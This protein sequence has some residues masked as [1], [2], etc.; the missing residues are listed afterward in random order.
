MKNYLLLLL[1]LACFSPLSAQT[2]PKILWGVYGGLTRSF[3]QFPKVNYQKTNALYAAY[4]D[5]LQEMKGTNFFGIQ[6]GIMI[7]FPLVE[8]WQ[9]RLL[10]CID[11]SQADF[12]HIYTSRSIENW[13]YEQTNLCLPIQAVW[14]MT[15]KEHSFYAFLGLNPKINFQTDRSLQKITLKKA[16]VSL[17]FGV[18]YGKIKI[19]KA[20]PFA[21]ELRFSLG[22]RDRLIDENSL[23]YVTIGAFK[24][25]SVGLIF[26]FY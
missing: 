12:T 19:R 20:L 18:G 9:I 21:P 10:P 22:L 7:S 11:L 2:P 16:D 24:Y 23:S 14:K 6:G 17:D 13:H 25:H 5:T 4:G 15:A 8:R 26:H 3:W 1:F